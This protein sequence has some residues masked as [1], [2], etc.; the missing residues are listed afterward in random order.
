M[1]ASDSEATLILRLGGRAGLERIVYK[2]YDLMRAD[3][4]L[5]PQFD[6]FAPT[7]S[8]FLRLKIRTVDWL[9]WMMGAGE[10]DGPDLFVAHA[11][12]HIDNMSYT[13]MM[14][15]YEQV[16]AEIHDVDDFT[17]TEL[18]AILE[19]QRDPIVDP[20][21]AF[22]RA[23]EERMEKHRLER[24]EKAKKFAK[25][26]AKSAQSI[27]AKDPKGRASAQEDVSR[28]VG[29]VAEVSSNASPALPRKA[30]EKRQPQGSAAGAQGAEDF[31]PCADEAPMPPPSQQP[32]VLL[33]GPA[34]AL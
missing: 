16:L 9:E 34:A 1:D 18:L 3:G 32:V 31:T 29:K 11:S 28:S 10:Y 12:M 27:Q 14:K 30:R 21:G 20:D 13:R 33:C 26:K 6:R 19:A 22:A 8:T 4:L 17:K 15:L 2:L 24:Q 5:G 23:A 7:G 25:K